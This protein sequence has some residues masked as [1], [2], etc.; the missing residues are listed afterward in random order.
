[1]PHEQR[2]LQHQG[3]PLDQ[4][5]GSTLGT[6]VVRQLGVQPFDGAVQPRVRPRSVGELGENA[7]TATGWAPSTRRTSRAWTLPEPSQIEFSGASR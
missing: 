4:P 6:L 2:T 3:H 1:M 7:S 5:A